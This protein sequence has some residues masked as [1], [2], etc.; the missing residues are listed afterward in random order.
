MNLS[1]MVNGLGKPGMN[2]N[3]INDSEQIRDYGMLVI[4]SNWS[5]LKNQSER[6]KYYKK[7]SLEWV[8]YIA[9]KRE[10]RRLLGDYVLKEDDLT[11]HVAHEDASFTTTWSIDLH[12][13]RP[14]EYPV[15]PGTGIQSDDRPC[16]NLSLSC[17]LPMSLFP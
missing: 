12:R 1:L 16:S 11:K 14:R 5:Y 15:F 2:K 13:A 9:G 4:Y 8:A 10:S 17:S 6:R 7:R 3:Q